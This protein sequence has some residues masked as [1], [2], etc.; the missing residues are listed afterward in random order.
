MTH[1]AD[2]S[3][4]DLAQARRLL[5]KHGTA[6]A[7]FAFGRRHS[8][9]SSQT[10]ASLSRPQGELPLL[11]LRDPA[12][13]LFG[14][15]E[16]IEL[17]GSG[18]MGQV[19]RARQVS[20]DRNVAV[21]LL[22]VNP[23]A[24]R[25]FVARFEREAQNAAR[26]NHPNIVAV[27]EV[28]H[29]DELHFF[30]MRLVEGPTLATILKGSGKLAPERAA[31]LMCAVGEAVD[32][33]HRLGV[34][35][36]DLKPANVLLDENGVPHV[37]DFGLARRLDAMLDADTGEISGTPN[38]MAP[39]QARGDTK[40][41]AVGTDIWG[42]GAILYELVTGEP[43][44][45]G[46]SP[47]ATLH[48]VAAGTVRSAR[49]NHPDLSR[50]LDAIILKCL[51]RDITQR[52]ASARA[53][54]DDLGRFIENRPVQ[55][56]PLNAVQRLWR[57]AER[58]PHIAVLAALFSLAVL[59]AVIGISLQWR[60]ADA[61][62]AGAQINAQKAQANA[63]TA[64]ERLWESRRDAALRLQTDGNGF[65]ALP[66]LIANIDEQEK[67]GKSSDSSIERREVGMILSQG[68]TLI[69]R[70]IMPGVIPLAAGLSPDGS[71]LALGLNDQTVRWYDTS[72]LTER[73]RVDVSNQP[74]SDGEIRLPRLL[75]FVDNQRL[76]VT[77][78][79][80]EYWVSPVDDDTYLIDL[81]RARIVEAPA[82]FADLTNANYSADGRYALLRNRHHEI[83]LWQVEP[84][85]AVSARVPETQ[86]QSIEGR[87]WM[88][89]RS[90]HVLVSL[91][92]RMAELRLY[93]AQH[94]TTPKAIALPEGMSIHAWAQS[95]DGA[96]LALG[97]TNGRIFLLD[98]TTRKLRQ[99][100]TQG[101]REI[102]WLAFSEDDAWLA[103]V[104]LGGMTY[105]F[106]VAT[107]EPLTNSQMM[108]DFT[109]REVAISHRERLLV[110]SGAGDTGPGQTTAWRLS[111]PSPNGGNAARLLSAPTR[112]PT[113]QG[114]NSLGTSLQSG[115]LATAAMDGEI[116][117]WRIPQSQIVPAR[118]AEQIPGMLYFDGK[119]IVD[120]EYT[121]L[122]IVSTDG[123]G[124]TPWVEL[125]QPVGFA[126]LVDAGRTLI[127]TSGT[128]L[129]VFDATTMRLRYPPVN[130]GNTPMHLVADAHGDTGVLGFG[131]N[132]AAGFE[133]RLQAYD[134]ESG[135]RRPGDA[136]VKGPLR[137]LELSVDGSRLLATGPSNGA[138]TIFD[139]ATLRQLG[140]YRHDSDAPVMWASFAD[141]A[142]RDQ[143]QLL[144]AAANSQAKGTLGENRIVRWDPLSGV[145]S[146]RRALHETAPIG[147][148]AVAGK[149]FVA[150]RSEDVFDPG[151]AN[152]RIASSGLADPTAVLAL[153]H[154]GRLVAHAFRSMVQLYDSTTA[155]AVGPQL[156]SEA[157]SITSAADT[158]AQ[159]A[160]SA[161]DHVL[162]GRTLRG[163]WL[164]WPIAADNR[165]LAEIQ[166]DA[167]LLTAHP[168][169]SHVLQL[170]EA[171]EHARLRARDPGPPSVPP[172]RPLPPSARAVV[173]A[174]IPMRDPATSP[175]LLDL[176]D[177]YTLAPEST[178]SFM[179]HVIS[180]MRNGPLGVIRLDDVD[181]D[182]RG[183]IELNW[184]RGRAKQDRSSDWTAAR[185]SGI[186]I[187]PVPI[188]A[189][190]VLLLAVQDVPQPD[191]V[192]YASVR[193]HYVDGS[194]AVLPIR[195]QREVPGWS[196]SDR[197]TPFAWT[198][199]DMH[200][201][202]GDQQQAL[203][204]SPR[205]PNPH[206]ERLIATLDL[207][208]ARDR[209]AQPVFFAVTAEP[210]IAAANSRSKSDKDGVK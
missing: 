137:Q 188:A 101:G 13:R 55:A 133:V 38:Y 199:G 197:P 140:S 107:G 154:D 147:I 162:L 70:M 156:P 46:E 196:E 198:S 8:G 206:P 15:Y 54:A 106:D 166:E 50:D 91:D 119:H 128:Q 87:T 151:T 7:E 129:R 53:L 67:A 171:S 164:L 77:L 176:T 183:L 187:P 69:D 93:D 31:E 43:P 95:S 126:D 26:L 122:R 68:V 105:A 39:E 150:G 57:A 184:Q 49:R 72:T 169:G 110:A 175:L 114:F 148:I 182:M 127:A 134:L 102:V 35:H 71:L 168:Q 97:D 18:G 3:P 130:L 65:E 131:G 205:L 180:N 167:R 58:Q 92:R 157:V 28:G 124:L 62:A 201:L 34:L 1:P 51:A 17:I 186:R 48:L 12:Q 159:L 153:S 109:L 195:T 22:A 63:A 165:P 52:Y 40:Q 19:Y 99:L 14:D 64:S 200:R 209:F 210:V 81:A 66:A 207:E 149:P 123:V 143:G 88:L 155:V 146:E 179:F 59:T 73:G 44:F 75:R 136:V 138:T 74:T 116:R 117:L 158:I 5:G 21:K 178:T 112:A 111:L 6:V 11:D 173:G 135:Q 203:L 33:A 185:T 115:L 152:E 79:W 192:P 84:W 190:H 42:L 29:I 47:Q 98:T 89:G 163:Y 37:A 113:G 61:N 104:R 80:V 10:D 23:W 118:A 181:Y 30:S 25:D 141:G 56:R 16:L 60:R 4:Y 132:G 120:V 170:P 100:P 94:L 145:V 90:A 2:N 208:P 45:L 161:D 174:P 78:D 177:A 194:T 193:L 96:T 108:Q 27:Y 202:I 125:P 9:G 82:Q 32:Y 191:E 36:L 139:T 24:S 204:S 83:Q 41:I 172:P 85:R 160:F 189:L 144:I 20:L 121:K 86:T 142:T 103:A 76:R